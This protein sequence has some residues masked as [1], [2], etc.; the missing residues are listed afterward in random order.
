MCQKKRLENVIRVFICCASVEA[1]KL[2]KSVLWPTFATLFWGPP[3]FLSSGYQGPGFLS[4]VVKWMGHETDHLPPS[5]AEVKNV[6]SY[7]S[8]PPICL[9]GM[10]HN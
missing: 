1:W 9:N 8:T 6:W 2:D 10:V 3:S 7:T 4:P 5:R